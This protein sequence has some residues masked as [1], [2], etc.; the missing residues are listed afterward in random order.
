MPESSSSSKTTQIILQLVLGA[1]VGYGGLAVGRAL[2]R[3][4]NRDQSFG[5]PDLVWLIAGL[6]IAIFLAIAIHEFGH[7][8]A[9]LSQRFRFW[10]YIVGP[11]RIQR[12]TDDRIE[13]GWNT[14]LQLAGG[15]AASVPSDN[16]NLARRMAV[17]VAGGPLASLLLGVVA[18]GLAYVLSHPGVR[19]VSILIGT[20][21]FGIAVVT[22]LPMRTSNFHSYGARLLMY[23]FQRDR[24]ERWARSA[25][26]TSLALSGTRPRDWNPEMVGGLDQI[27]DHSLDG[28]GMATMLFYYEIDRGDMEAAANHLDFF[29][30]HQ[31]AYPEPFRPGMRLEGAWFEGVV[32][33]RADVARQWLDQSSGGMLVEPQTRLRATAAV[34]LAE[35]NFKEA[36]A[37]AEEALAVLNDLKVRRGIHWAEESMV[38]HICAAIATASPN[39]AVPR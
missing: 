31:D 2:A 25:A 3:S 26:L 7:V 6:V 10:L 22:L 36:A 28:V 20:V 23:W 16:H 27:M 11:L 39:D 21:S 4:G 17:M 29:L 35:G 19:L 38:Q 34:L 30:A 14:S 5:R 9:G 12:T 33:R 13:A 32:R 15:I 8:V 1:L 18:L 24:M 37:K